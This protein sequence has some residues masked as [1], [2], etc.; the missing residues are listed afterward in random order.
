M[1]NRGGH[2]LL[3]HALNIHEHS[4]QAKHTLLQCASL[5]CN[6]TRLC[7]SLV[8]GVAL[9]H[10]IKVDEFLGEGGHVI[11]EAKSVFADGICGEDII[12]LTFALAV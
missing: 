11:F 4:I 5:I 1:N 6:L 12:T 10:D 2:L 7:G 3:L 9:D 8:S